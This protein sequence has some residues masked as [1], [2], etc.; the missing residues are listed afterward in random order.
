MYSEE[1]V[2]V[3]EG[4]RTEIYNGRSVCVRHSHLC[5]QRVMVGDYV[6]RNRS[7]E[8]PGDTMA[9]SN[10]CSFDGVSVAEDVT[11]RIGCLKQ[12]YPVASFNTWTLPLRFNYK[13][14]ILGKSVRLAQRTS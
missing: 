9:A 3:G 11:V 5:V 7:F 4:E 1:K 12:H 2:A 14:T 10:N 8:Q 6:V 13:T